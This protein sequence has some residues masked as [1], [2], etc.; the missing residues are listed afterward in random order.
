MNQPKQPQGNFTMNLNFRRHRLPDA[1]QITGRISAPESP[2]DQFKY[3][4][5]ERFDQEGRRY[6]I[7]PVEVNRTMR[8]ALNS[9][10]ARGTH[11]IVIRENGFKTFQTLDDGK[12]PNPEYQALSEADRAHQNAQPSY[13][14]NW[15]REPGKDRQLRASAWDR[16]ES[17][18]GPWASGNTQYPITKAELA[19]LEQAAMDPDAAYE[20]DRAHLDALTASEPATVDDL[21]ESGQVTRGMPDFGER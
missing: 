6:W 13:W 10:A 21:I 8:A 5:F 16:G 15:T 20:A 12:T 9:T 4:A 3:Q 11:F 18:Y 2:N 1:P 19:A 7:G 17:Q 14:A